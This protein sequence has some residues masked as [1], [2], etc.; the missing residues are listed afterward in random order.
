[1]KKLLLTGLACALLVGCAQEPLKKQTASGKAEGEYP[2][3]TPEQVAD[4][5]VQH[6]NDKGYVIEEQAKNYVICSKEMEG[7][8]AIMMQ[9]MIGNSYSTTPQLKVRYSISK[10]RNG[11]K[12]WANAWSESQMAFGQI[13]KMQ[14]DS[15]NARNEL[16]EVLD[17]KLPALLKK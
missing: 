17:K 11:T 5:I 16:Q 13:N 15:N 3:Y 10:F 8:G 7:G 9:M 12:V 1:M 14:L 2:Q 4:A 6:C